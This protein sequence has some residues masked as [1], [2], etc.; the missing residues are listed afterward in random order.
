ML[1]ASTLATLSLMTAGLAVTVAKAE[2]AHVHGEAI[3]QL[4]ID[5]SGALATFKSPAAD[6]VGFERHPETDAE[7]QAV[8]DA[9]AQLSDFTALFTLPEAAGCTIDHAHADFEVEAAGDDHEDHDHHEEGEEHHDEDEH[10]EEGEEHH[11]EDEHHDEGE[12]HHDE[13]EHH[14][15]GEEHHDDHEGHDEHEHHDEDEMQAEAGHAEFHAE[16]EMTCADT[17]SLTSLQTSVFDLF[18]SLEA[19]EVEAV[20]PAGQS[21]AELTPQSAEMS[22]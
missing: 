18:P 4:V 15:E 2:D 7:K 3:L 6:I 1:K 8:A 21:G 22:L 9:L 14:E 19:L 12:E 11:D 16:F 10:H 17:S 5:D 20:T 13:D